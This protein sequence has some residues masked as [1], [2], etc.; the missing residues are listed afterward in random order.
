M[1]PNSILEN[2]EKNMTLKKK[3]AEEGR[4]ERNTHRKPF[5]TKGPLEKLPGMMASKQ[6]SP[7]KMQE[8]EKKNSIVEKKEKPDETDDMGKSTKLAVRAF[9]WSS[10]GLISLGGTINAIEA[11]MHNSASTLDI[12]GNL[13]FAAACS[14]FT[15][16][17]AVRL[18]SMI[19]DGR[20][21]SKTAESE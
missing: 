4:M 12:I 15:I 13:G 1:F 19:K 11:A 9:F 10:F 18:A 7:A 17:S 16:A 6:T 5:A 8:E 21:K 14:I 2:G 3:T 20:E